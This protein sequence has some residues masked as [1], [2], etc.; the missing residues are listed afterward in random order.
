V[1]RLYGILIP[2]PSSFASL[3]RICPPSCRRWRIARYR[4]R[5]RSVNVYYDPFLALQQ[6]LEVVLVVLVR[7]QELVLVR[8]C[9]R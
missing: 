6:G 9:G 4:R 2:E 3:Y 8:V 7:V 1:C 5:G